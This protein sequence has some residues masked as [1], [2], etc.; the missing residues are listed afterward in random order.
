MLRT[1]TKTVRRLVDRGVLPI[2]PHMGQ[3]VVILRTT[4]VQLVTSERRS[5][6][7]ARERDS[8]DIVPT[9]MPS[10]VVRKYIGSEGL[11]D[12]FHRPR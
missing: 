10:R 7:A 4:V 3:R 1:S 11:Q 9:H 6:A 5:S 8:A 12:A 2:L